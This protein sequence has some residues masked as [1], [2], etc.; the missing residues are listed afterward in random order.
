MPTSNLPAASLSPQ[1]PVPARRALLRRL[2]IWY[3]SHY[4]R[5]ERRFFELD[6]LSPCSQR[7]KAGPRAQRPVGEGLS[8][9]HLTLGTRSIQPNASGKQSAIIR[10]FPAQ[11]GIHIRCRSVRRLPVPLQPV[12]QARRESLACRLYAHRS[13][14]LAGALL[15]Q[16][17]PF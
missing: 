15:L 7:E 5:L 13:Q 14:Q 6:R 11:A 3:A 10:V 4:S 8:G 12:A 9:R 1:I 2:T 16:H 17:Q